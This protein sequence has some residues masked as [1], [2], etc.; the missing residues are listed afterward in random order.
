MQPLKLDYTTFS[1]EFVYLF[2]GGTLVLASIIPIEFI[3]VS[4][5]LIGCLGMWG[6]GTFTL[7]LLAYF[8]RE[9]RY[10][11]MATAMIGVLYP[12]TML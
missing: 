10:L 12:L 11:S 1:F 8:I 7:V 3:G 6:I 2:T 5:R 4:Y 9:W